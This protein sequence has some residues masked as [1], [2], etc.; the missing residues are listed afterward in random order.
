MTH[1]FTLPIALALDVALGDPRS[2][3]HPVRLMGSLATRVETRVRR[4]GSSRLHGLTGW[5]LVVV[6]ILA[7][8]AG[9]LAVARRIHPVLELSFSAL[10]I[11]VAIAPRDLSRHARRVERELRVAD[12]PAARRAVGCIVG[13]DTDEL[14]AGE[15]SRAAV[16]AV[17]ESTVDGITAP[18]FYACLLGPLGALGYRAINTLD[19]MWGHRDER[20]E[21]FGW[22]AARADD[23]ATYLPARLTVLWIA[24]GAAVCRLCPLSAWR[25]AWRDGKKHPSPNSGLSEA[26]FAGALGVVLG[27]RNRYD[28]QWGEART[29]GNGSCR[30]NFDT[31]PKAVALMW[32]ATALCAATLIAVVLLVERLPWLRGA[33]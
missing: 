29:F 10:L 18:L 31:I 14:D 25:I 28:G 9:A 26:A 27:G 30:P 7:A 5:V 11:Y 8:A 13:R 2:A 20:Y 4:M 24:M 23:I 6:T 15:I 1:W 22:A 32:C 33:L 3:W 12:L 19:S 21:H 16:E 17:A